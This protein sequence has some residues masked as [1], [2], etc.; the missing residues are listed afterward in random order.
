MQ[1]VRSTERTAPTPRLRPRR[2]TRI[3]D[4]DLPDGGLQQGSV[5]VSTLFATLVPCLRLPYFGACA[6]LAG[7]ATQ[8]D[9]IGLV[10]AAHTG[11]PF[12]AVEAR[13]LGE[14]PVFGPLSLRLAIDLLAPLA[15]DTVF[16]GSTTVWTSP[17]FAG[18]ATLLVAARLR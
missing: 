18:E 12:V 3:D 2:D 5:Q 16:A 1:Q 17:S 8:I 13:A 6:L 9:G 4:G 11:R 15:H 10:E 14:L 7:G